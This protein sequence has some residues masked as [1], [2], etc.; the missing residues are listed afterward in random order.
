MKPG[1]HFLHRRVIEHGLPMEYVVTRIARGIIYYRPA[2]GGG[3]ECTEVENFHKVCLKV[4]ERRM[5]YG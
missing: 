5:C 1:L 3:A 2:S 4:L